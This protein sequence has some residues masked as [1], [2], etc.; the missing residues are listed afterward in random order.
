MSLILSWVIQALTILAAAYIVPG[1]TVT[2]FMT[3]L[4]IAV[5]LAVLNILVK[6]ILLLLTLPINILTLGLFTLVINVLILMLA[7]A[8][9]T[10]FQIDGF[11]PALLFGL[12]LAV[13]NAILG[14]LTK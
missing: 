2:S 7:A 14:T 10:G 1:V 6:P 13:L 3:A 12:A 9:V 5:V 4:L 11:I 8:L